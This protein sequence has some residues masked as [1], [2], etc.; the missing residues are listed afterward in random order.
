MF[1]R[2]L[3]IWLAKPGL[4]SRGRHIACSTRKLRSWNSNFATAHIAK[5]KEKHIV[6]EGVCFF[7]FAISYNDQ[8]ENNEYNENLRCV[9]GEE[10][11]LL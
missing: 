3:L 2:S 8:L 5:M 9:H 6:F 7:M 1:A 10:E 11:T 4:A